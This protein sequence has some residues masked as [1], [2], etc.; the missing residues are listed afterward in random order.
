MQSKPLKFKSVK[1]TGPHGKKVVHYN[2]KKTTFQGLCELCNVS[3]S[4]VHRLPF[5]D[6]KYVLSKINDWAIKKHY[7][8]APN[9]TTF[10]GPDGSPMWND[11]VV[12]YT[13]CKISTVIIRIQQWVIDGDCDWLMRPVNRNKG[14]RPGTTYKHQERAHSPTPT[15]SDV[16]PGRRAASTIKPAGTW[17]LENL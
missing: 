10:Y 16:T 12:K 2:G 9:T 5:D 7:G 8:V 17:E 4:M 1:L 13:G 15:K 3:I 6:P 14:P 11:L